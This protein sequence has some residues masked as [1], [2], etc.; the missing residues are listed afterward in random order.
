MQKEKLA[1]VKEATEN[2]RHGEA[3]Y[4]VTKH[5]KYLARFQK[6]FKL[7]NDLQ[8]IDGRSAIL[9]LWITQ[10]AEKIYAKSAG[11]QS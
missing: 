8:K 10:Q 6:Q 4:L 7:L 2:H 3:R 1:K 11:I 9:I 5:F